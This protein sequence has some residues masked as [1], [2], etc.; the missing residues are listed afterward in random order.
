MF[1]IHVIHPMRRDITTATNEFYLQWDKISQLADAAKNY[2]DEWVYGVKDR[3]EYWQKLGK[4]L[5]KRLQIKPQFS[6]P[7]NYGEY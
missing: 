6:E 5:Y 3:E 2:L 1:H 7:I 4:E